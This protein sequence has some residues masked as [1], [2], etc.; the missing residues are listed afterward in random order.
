MKDIRE[1]SQEEKIKIIFEEGKTEIFDLRSA[2]LSSANL[3][4]AKIDEATQFSEIKIKKSQIEIILKT[5][6]EVEE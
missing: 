5:M 2:N 4:F 6:F 1:L 3:R